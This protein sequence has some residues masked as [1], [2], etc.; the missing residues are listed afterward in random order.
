[1]NICIYVYHKLIQILYLTAVL[2]IILNKIYINNC[3]KYKIIDTVFNM[4]V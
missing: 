1:M 3:F 2:Y 4:I